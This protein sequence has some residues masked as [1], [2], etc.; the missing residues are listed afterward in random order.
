MQLEE[1]TKTQIVLLTLLTS[2]VTSIATGI[3]TVAIIDQAPPGVTQTINRVVERTVEVIVPEKTQG[4]AVNKT[5][6]VREEDFIVDA[7]KTN[8]PNIVTLFVVEDDKVISVGVGF[9]VD[10]KGIVAADKALFRRAGGAVSIRSFLI[11]TQSGIRYTALPLDISHERLLFFKADFS[12]KD[13]EDA[14]QESFIE[15]TF[16]KDESIR[17]GQSAIA[18]GFD[19]SLSVLVGTVSRLEIDKNA[20]STPLSTIYTTL[21][22]NS[23]FAGG[24]L[25]DIN[26]DILGITLFGEGNVLIA[27]PGSEIVEVLKKYY[28]EEEVSEEAGDL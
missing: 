2:F 4:A 15:P 11:K 19:E 10:P 28:E 17:L 18:L 26:T 20:S 21:T 16:S 27:V 22:A 24:A 13:G 12:K 14:V 3:T 7:T 25:V 8:S 9:V 1:L 23:R 5:I 6:I